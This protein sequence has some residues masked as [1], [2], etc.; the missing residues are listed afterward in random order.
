MRKKND[1]CIDFIKIKTP[2]KDYN[3]SEK[4][5]EFVIFKKT[6]DLETFYYNFI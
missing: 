6:I 2:N 4:N 1:T 5:K 3:Q